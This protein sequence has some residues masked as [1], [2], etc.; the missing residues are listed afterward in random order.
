[1]PVILAGLEVD[2]VA[3][4]YLLDRSPS[5]WQRPI[6]SVTKIVCPAGWVCQA[7][8]APGV[9]WTIPPMTREGGDGVLT[10]SM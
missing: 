3:R 7:V 8:R 5:R 6:P 1:M 4:P 9:K 2:A 10:T